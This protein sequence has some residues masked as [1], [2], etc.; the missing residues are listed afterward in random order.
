MLAPKLKGIIAQKVKLILMAKA[1]PRWKSQKFA[2]V[3]TI[4]S[5]VSNFKPSKIG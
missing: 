3:G 4:I 2:L 1:G 5:E